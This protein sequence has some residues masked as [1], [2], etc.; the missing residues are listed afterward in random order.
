MENTR[1]KLRGDDAIKGVRE[2]IT[3]TVG[4]TE[5]KATENNAI[6][7]EVLKKK[8]KEEALWMPCQK[9]WH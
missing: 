4:K 1:N 8:A 6:I 2:N 7:I 3:I 5:H 9:A